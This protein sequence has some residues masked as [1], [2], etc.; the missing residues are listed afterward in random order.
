MSRK[1]QTRVGL[2]VAALLAGVLVAPTA[3]A[4]AAVADGKGAAR[5]V[6]RQ[7]GPYQ[8]PHGT[9]RVRLDPVDFTLHIDNPWWPMRPG[10]SWHY[11]ERA[12]E[13]TTKVITTVT[14]RTK[15]VGGIRARVVHDVAREHGR[16][17]EDT[18]DWYAQ[19]S[20]GS[21][22]YLGELSKQFEHG[23]LASTAGSWTY[24]VD[25][26]QAGVVVPA[27]PG[28]GCTYREEHHRP[29]AED[30]ARV[31]SVSE[32][33]RVPTGFYAHT[34]HT[35]NSSPVEPR[36]LENKFYARGV[37]PV[38]ELDLSPELGTAV[39]VRITRHR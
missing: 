11:V 27:R 36:A 30:R 26:G 6:C 8:L 9:Q 38:L 25:G 2:G 17:I 1:H 4:V 29:D 21:I 22:W 33:L 19:D 15:V 13:E 14:H 32:G 31:L 37:G 24:G 20:G 39:L 35:A 18:F 7:P 3:S 23:H 28:V 12:G 10:T 16:V 34:L 5:T